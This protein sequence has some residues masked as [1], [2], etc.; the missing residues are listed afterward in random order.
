MGETKLWTVQCC[1]LGGEGNFRLLREEGLEED[2][3]STTLLVRLVQQ[4][5][6]LAVVL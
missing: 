3:S 5:Q 4:V 2:E 6:I 1:N